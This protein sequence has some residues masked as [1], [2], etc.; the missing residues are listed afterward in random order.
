MVSLQHL[1]QY[2]LS[3]GLTEHELA[4]DIGVPK[5]TIHGILKGRNPKSSDI[6][7]KLARYFHMDVDLLRFGK[8]GLANSQKKKEDSADNHGRYRK[9]PILSWTQVCYVMERQDFPMFLPVGERMVETEIS[10]MRVFALYVNDNSMEPLFHEGEIIFLNPDLEPQPGDYVVFWDY[11]DGEDRGCIRQL[12]KIQERYVL[13][14]LN[15]Q[16]KDTPFTSHQKIVGRV[17]RLRMNL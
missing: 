13:H 1:I 8:L 9:V 6:W 15:T 16:F 17:V 2:Q 11:M 14:P 5:I 4:E 7:K 3:E 10:G 12:K